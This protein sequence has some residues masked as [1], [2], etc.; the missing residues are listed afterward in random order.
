[1]GGHRAAVGKSKGLYMYSVSPFYQKPFNGWWG[2]MAHMAKS[3]F[4]WGLFVSSLT[5][6]AYSL[7]QWA[8]HDFHQR[9]LK[10]PADYE[11][12]VIE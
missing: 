5:I 11:D 2:E 7:V 9:G 12:E 4:G 3:H 8:N 1:M 6:G 10:N